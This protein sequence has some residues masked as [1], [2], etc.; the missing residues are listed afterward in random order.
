MGAC[1][2]ITVFF[3]FLSFALISF[4]STFRYWCVHIALLVMVVYSRFDTA[5]ISIVIIVAIFSNLG[6]GSTSGFSAYSI[7]NK[8]CGYLLGEA[9]PDEIDKQLRGGDSG[10]KYDELGKYFEGLDLPSKFVNKACLCGSGLKAKKCCMSS[11]K[12]LPRQPPVPRSE[13]EG[14]AVIGQG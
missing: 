13:F 4:P 12:K 2:C 6:F 1:I 3:R 8:G 10:P 5:V 14:F 7:F 9:R 11:T